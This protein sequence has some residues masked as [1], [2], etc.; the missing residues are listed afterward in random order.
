MPANSRHPFFLWPLV[1][2]LVDQCLGAVTSVL[3]VEE[4]LLGVGSVFDP[5]TVAVFW[6][7]LPAVHA[8]PSCTVSLIVAPLSE[9][10]V[11]GIRVPTAQL[12]VAPVV[13]GTVVFE[14]DSRWLTN[15]QLI[16]FADTLTNVVFAGRVS[17]TTTSTA[18]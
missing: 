2:P 12:T 11:K 17:L 7:V 8:L 9:D 4:L 13:H 3:A 15:E 5:L 14:Q 6:T 18:F 16:L 10:K 1:L